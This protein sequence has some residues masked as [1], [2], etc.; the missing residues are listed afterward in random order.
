M[1]NLNNLEADIKIKFK[2]FKLLKQALTHKS[3]SSNDNYEKLEFLGDR[4]LGLVISKK[5]LE[6]YPNEK[7]GVLDKKL[8]Y[9]VN[10]NSCYEVGK[11]LNLYKYIYVGNSKK[12][13]NIAQ[14]KIISDCIEA[15]IGAIYLDKGFDKVEK[16]IIYH[17]SFLIKTSENTK[18]DAKTRLQEYSLKKFKSLPIYKLI[19]NTGPRHSPEFKVAV[20]LKNTKYINGIGSSKKAAEQEAAK[21][22]LK[23]LKDE[24]AR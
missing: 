4:V 3:F 22:F 5:L 24:L 9:L 13:L 12:N 18:V 6:I 8:A 1:Q 14:K 15:I 21:E 11:N 17:W 2:N 10:K 16:F 7:E 19:S 23:I 20:K